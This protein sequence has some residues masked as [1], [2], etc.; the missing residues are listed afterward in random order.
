MAGTTDLTNLLVAIGTLDHHTA[1]DLLTAT[2][3]LAAA[4]L[5]RWDEFFLADRLA[6]V[7]EGDT[8]LHA[9]GSATAPI[10]YEIW[11][12]AAPTFGPETGEVPNRYMRR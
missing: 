5:E 10:R 8:A 3:S 1:V 4:R 7:Y 11:S 6:Q 12:P 2:P 9:A